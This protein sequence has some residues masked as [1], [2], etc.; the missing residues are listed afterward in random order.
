MK[1]YSSNANMASADSIPTT[2]ASGMFVTG[3]R[4]AVG[5]LHGSDDARIVLLAMELAWRLHYGERMDYT[6]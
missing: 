3:P 1:L 4:M 6:P 2:G 5:G